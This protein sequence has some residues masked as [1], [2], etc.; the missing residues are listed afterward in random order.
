MRYV[1]TNEQIADILT[2]GSFSVE[3]QLVH[4]TATPSD[5]ASE[6][7]LSLDLLLAES[8]SLQSTSNVSETGGP[9]E[10]SRRDARKACIP[11]RPRLAQQRANPK[12]QHQHPHVRRVTPSR[13]H[14]S[15]VGIQKREAALHKESL[16]TLRREAT[17]RRKTFAR[18]PPIQICGRQPLDT[19][20]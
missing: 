18:A 12:R 20:C 8:A 11:Q 14:R 5:E 17:L 3:M 9:T 19:E 16:A 15:H 6:A 4:V 10:H 13:L 7:I 2:K 1:I